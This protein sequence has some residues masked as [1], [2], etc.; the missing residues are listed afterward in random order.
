[1]IEKIKDKEI[2]NSKEYIQQLIKENILNNNNFNN[3]YCTVY[4][5]KEETYINNIKGWMNEQIFNEKENTKGTLIFINPCN[6]ANW[7]HECC[8]WFV[9]KNI[10]VKN[11]K[12]FWP[13][14]GDIMIE[15]Y[16]LKKI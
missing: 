6:I 12:C 7:S 4:I 13:P 16:N 15:E 9:S 2:I 8:Y 14:S 3:E 5:S 11:N 10:L 1:M